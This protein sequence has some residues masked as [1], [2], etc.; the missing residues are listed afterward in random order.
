[1]NGVD[2]KQ[3]KL[4]KLQTIDVQ[5]TTIHDGPGYDDETGVGT[6]RGP[7]FFTRN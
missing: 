4:Y 1:V 5:T 7:A 3:G 2:N 6:P